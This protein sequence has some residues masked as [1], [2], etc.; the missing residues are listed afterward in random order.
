MKHFLKSGI[1]A[2]TVLTVILSAFLPCFAE[3]DTFSYSTSANSGIRNTVCTTLDGTGASDYYT[4]SYAYSLL[5][6]LSETAL[7]NSLRTLMSDT[8][9]KQTTYANC[10]DYATITDCENEN[11]KITTLYTS[12]QTAKSEFDGGKGWNREHVWPKSLGGF[13]TDG[14]GADLHHIRPSE[15]STNTDRGNKKYGYV[16]NGTQSVGN[17]SGIFGGTFDTVYYEPDDSVKG[18][19]ARICLYVYVRWGGEYAKSSN[20]NNVFQSIDVLLEWCALDPVDTWEMGRNEVVE[21]I[22]GNRNVFIDY[23]EL[24]WKL[25]G[26]EVPDNLV[27]PSQ[28]T[29]ADS[30][31]H[32]AHTAV[33]YAQEATCGQNGYSG[34]LYCSDCDTL[35]LGGSTIEA[36]G[37]HTWGEWETNTETEQKRVCSVC[38]AEET[39][40]VTPN[41]CPH[42]HTEYHNAKGANCTEAGYSGDLYCSDCGALIASGNEIPISGN[43]H[44]FDDWI[45]SGS[46]S[47]R[48]CKRCG[49]QESNDGNVQ[50]PTHAGCAATAVGN[51]SLLLSFCLAAFAV[52]KRKR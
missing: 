11:G 20:L 39:R 3:T 29:T 37:A 8:H 10:R 30:S 48:T 32:H 7:L 51:T 44:D 38:K 25:F 26:K 12:Y 16:T 2:L 49:T 21:H 34:D 24:A 15:N 9:T 35:L 31:C 27:T 17:L 5:S 4:G 36:T 46:H 23:P 14:A 19:V 45:A 1:A 28:N 33:K 22:Q 13:N 42:A 40:T 43:E 18:D 50:D 47:I 52:G 41:T 6:E